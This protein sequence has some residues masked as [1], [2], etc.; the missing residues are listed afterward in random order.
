MTGAEGLTGK[1]LA[2]ADLDGSGAVEAVDAQILEDLL[3]GKTY[4]ERTLADLLD[5]SLI[6]VPAHDSVQ[7]HASIR[8]TDAGRR[9]WRSILSTVHM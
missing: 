3:E 7:V 5:Q 4:G 1:A 6:T 8:L 2:A 9:I